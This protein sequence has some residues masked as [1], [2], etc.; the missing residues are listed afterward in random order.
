M[1]AETKRLAK[2]ELLESQLKKEKQKLALE[3]QREKEE[4]NSALSSAFEA[5]Y[6]SA[7]P[8]EKGKFTDSIKANLTGKT[9]ERALHHLEKLDAKKV[10]PTTRAKRV[11]KKASSVLKEAEA[12]EST[13]EVPENQALI[14]KE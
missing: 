2:I 5:I 3:K 13:P 12:I 8:K 11:L 6:K 14:Q 10:T 4:K 9:L 7:T 1:V